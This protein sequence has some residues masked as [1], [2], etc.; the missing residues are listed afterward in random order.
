MSPCTFRS[1]SAF[2]AI[3][4]AGLLA[5]PL[6]GCQSATSSMAHSAEEKAMAMLPQNAKDLANQYLSGMGDLNKLIDQMQNPQQALASLNKVEQTASKVSQA[7]SALNALPPDTRSNVVKAFGP[8][9]TSTNSTFMTH[10][11]SI[12]SDPSFGSLG[13]VLGPVLDKVSLFK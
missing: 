7:S 3:F 12:K 11:S 8:Q 4:C 1:L 10:L 9:L 6:T 13:S 5:T 2:A